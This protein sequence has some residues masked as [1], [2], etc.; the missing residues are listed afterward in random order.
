[1]TPADRALWASARTVADLG[2]LMAR[3]LEG[4]IRSRPAYTPG[5]GPEEE[6]S[7]LIP[8]L[9]ALNRAG[10]LTDDSQPGY[11]GPG[12]DG[13]RWQ[14]RAA[15]EGFITDKGLLDRVLKKTRRAGL[16][17]IVHHGAR[18]A[19]R[20]GEPV[21]WGDGHPY[22]TYGRYLDRRNVMHAWQGISHDA[23]AE[24][25]N[26]RQ[27]ALIEPEPGPSTRLWDTLTGITGR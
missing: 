4:D 25:V 24:L 27:V 1:M 3:W 23:L 15:I 13:R 7:E 8:L 20:N 14:Q 9:A 21:T 10:F 12:Y 11:D 19:A 26:A 22:T 6:T 5:V 17:A 18:R 2:A 16:L